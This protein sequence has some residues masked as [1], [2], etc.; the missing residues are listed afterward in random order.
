MIDEQKPPDE[1]GSVKKDWQI[2]VKWLNT[3]GLRI[4]IGIAIVLTLALVLLAST[5]NDPDTRANVLTVGILTIL[6]IIVTTI[7]AV[8]NRLMVEIME[9][10]ETEM[11][12]QRKAMQ[13]GLE[14]NQAM[15][16]QNQSMMEQ[17]ERHFSLSERPILAIKVKQANIQ[18]GRPIA[19][20]II[21]V[22]NK[23]RSAAVEIHLGINVVRPP[24]Q[25]DF[26]MHGA[27]WI[28]SA[29]LTAQE[30]D[31]FIFEN[32]REMASKPLTQADYDAI[33]ADSKVIFIYGEGR[34]ED[35]SGNKYVLEKW[36]V[37]F[38]TAY[39]W[40]KDTA[41]I[42]TIQRL[43]RQESVEIL[44]IPVKGQSDADKQTDKDR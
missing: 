27:S 39:G 23:G 32:E 17:T 22:T 20:I 34:Y 24:A 4:L 5:I 31:D 7:A 37:R 14:K 41:A 33:V 3:S 19:P 36:A 29:T 38:S 6:T 8:S 25:I 16:E 26:D 44:G 12:E 30:S 2:A 42:P 40:V 1:T 15:L 13:E 11:T 18:P 35:L 28:E 10:Q 9:R 43:Q 21:K